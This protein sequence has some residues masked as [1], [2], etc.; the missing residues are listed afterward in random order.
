MMAKMEL[1][2]SGHKDSVWQQFSVPFVF[3]AMNDTEW[4]WPRDG[5]SQGGEPR[6]KDDVA[7]TS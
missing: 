7:K 6:L 3:L 2:L 1:S 4:W 5:E